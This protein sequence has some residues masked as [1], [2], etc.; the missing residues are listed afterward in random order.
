MPATDATLTMWP[1][2]RGRIRRT[3]SFDP[4]ITAWRSISSMRMTV[5]SS[6][7]ANGPTGMIPALLT[8][9]SIGPNRR[10]TSSRNAVKPRR[11]VTSS[12]SPIGRPPGLAGGGGRRGGVHV[13]DGD[14]AALARQRERERLAD[15]AATAGDDGDLA[16]ERAGLRGHEVEN[17]LVTGR[18]VSGGTP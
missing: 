1:L 12:R 11:S 2:P 13:A 16:V 3:A 15:A 9:T 7:S 6:S 14:A 8:R 4:W 17:L 5:A 18:G 10:S